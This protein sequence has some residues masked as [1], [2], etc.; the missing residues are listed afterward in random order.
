MADSNLALEKY[1]G[2]QG[3]SLLYDDWLAL[4]ADVDN[5]CFYHDPDWF[6]AYFASRDVIDPTITFFVVR[7]GETDR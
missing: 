3:L 5:R 6:G 7:R 2:Q 4:M 1:D